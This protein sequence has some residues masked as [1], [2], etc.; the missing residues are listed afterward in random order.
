MKKARKQEKRIEVEVMRHGD[1]A[2]MRRIVPRSTVRFDVENQNMITAL[3]ENRR[4][5]FVNESGETWMQIQTMCNGKGELVAVPQVYK[6]FN[7]ACYTDVTPKFVRSGRAY[8]KS[9]M[10]LA[11]YCEMREEAH[12]LRKSAVPRRIVSCPKCGY[13]FE[14]GGFSAN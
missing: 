9:P 4:I 10:D 1:H 14:L 8:N 7:A 5:E 6:N 13:E 3:G 12:K 11:R 2:P